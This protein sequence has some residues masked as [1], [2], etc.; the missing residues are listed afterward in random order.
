MAVS[1]SPMTRYAPH[2]QR[3][4]VR[5]A[6]IAMTT[7]VQQTRPCYETIR[8]R[9][10]TRRGEPAVFAARFAAQMAPALAISATRAQA[11]ISSL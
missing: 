8:A 7:Q 6:A 4:I 10:A 3:S 2:G 5:P 9:A 1:N 11:A